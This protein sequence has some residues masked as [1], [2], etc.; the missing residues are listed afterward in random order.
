MIPLGLL[1]FQLMFGAV[2]VDADSTAAP[3][4]HR[5]PTP[6]GSYSEAIFGRY[7]ELLRE[8]MTDAGYAYARIDLTSVSLNPDSTRI[9]VD[10]LVVSGEPVRIAGLHLEGAR[11]FTPDR[12]GPRISDPGGAV[13]DR[14]T[15]ERIRRE[16][17][18]TGLYE[19]VEPMPP[20]YMDGRDVLPF[21]VREVT[22]GQV[23]GLLGWND[24]EWIGMMDITLRHATAIGHVMNLRIDRQ[25]PLETHLGV[26]S[27]WDRPLDLPITLDLTGRWTQQDTTFL[28]LSLGAGVD[29]AA[30]GLPRYGVWVERHR[31]ETGSVQLPD[32]V[33]GG[34]RMAGVR[35]RTASGTEAFF[36]TSGYRFDVRAGS[37]YRDDGGR[38]A[39]LNAEWERIIWSDGRLVGV[40]TGAFGVF[41][42]DSVRVDE[43]FRLGGASSFRGL[44]EG[45]IRTPRYI[46]NEIEG[47]YALDRDTY[48]FLFGG[49]AMALGR[50]AMLNLG[51]GFAYVTRVGIFRIT[52]ATMSDDWRRPVLHVRLTSGR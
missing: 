1:L 7:L 4:V 44:P 43:R 11:R 5:I 24:G 51:G 38:V 50:T 47:R 10:L 3:I 49:G 32:L 42:S 2:R 8:A 15:R 23:D 28:V 6:E 14:A 39:R 41:Q 36:P 22:P 9:H 25:R 48:G 33:E 45:G 26:R 12:V 21:E 35:Y 52:A 46:W 40:G 18:A 30:F 27:D 37:G 19:A 29:M 20:V 17:L 13:A 31:V 16:L 34:Y